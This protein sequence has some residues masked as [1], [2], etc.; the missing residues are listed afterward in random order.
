M[1]N[2]W[3]IFISVVVTI[4]IVGGGVFYV[5]QKQI[6]SVRA[7]NQVK[8]DDLNKQI[9]SLKSTAKAPVVSSSATPATTATSWKNYSNSK[10]GFS[11]TFNDL[12]Q[13]YVVASGKINDPN[14]TDELYIWLPTADKT[15]T[16]DKAGYWYPIVI[17][18]YTPENWAKNQAEAI[19]EA[20]TKLGENANY[21]F[22]YNQA[23]ADPTDGAKIFADIKNIVASFKI[24]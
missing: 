19:E 8:M 24:N 5:M 7:D 13:G 16:T 4:V 20:A 3:K 10:Y 18:V 1:S 17:S 23:Q 22:G 15:W 21:V 12:E 11:L 6:D 2:F 9:A 14:A